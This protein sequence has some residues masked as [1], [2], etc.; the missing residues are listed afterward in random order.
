MV[1]LRQFEAGIYKR[2][3]KK[4]QKRPWLIMFSR[5]TWNVKSVECWIIDFANGNH[6]N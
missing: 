6:D 1:T 5:N 2:K 4:A 3:R